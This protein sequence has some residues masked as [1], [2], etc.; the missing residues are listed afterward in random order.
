MKNAIILTRNLT[1][2]NADHLNIT[3][4]YLIRFFCHNN[5]ICY[6]LK[7]KNN[8]NSFTILNGFCNVEYSIP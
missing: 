8:Y 3:M 1:F 5:K 2:K 7:K 4:K 6:A